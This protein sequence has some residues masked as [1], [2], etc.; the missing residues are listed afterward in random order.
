MTKLLH[1][2]NMGAGCL[3]L[4]PKSNHMRKAE[5]ASVILRR[6]FC[7]WPPLRF[8]GSS[9]VDKHCAGASGKEHSAY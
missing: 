9:P 6:Q 7:F 5:P 4:S 2:V 1:S 3:D 8:R